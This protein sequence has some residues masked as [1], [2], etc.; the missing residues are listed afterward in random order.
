MRNSQ[1]SASEVSMRMQVLVVVTVGLSLASCHSSPNLQTRLTV[2]SSYHELIDGAPI[3]I[4]GK[5]IA[6]K[7]VGPEVRS[8]DEHRYPLRLRHVIVQVENTLK[9]TADAGAFYRY[10]WSPDHAMVGPWGIVGPG[11]RCVFSLVKEDGVLRSTMDLYPSHIE[12]RSGKHA[13]YSPAA[14]QNARESIAELLL[15]PGDDV[16]PEA[17]AQSLLIASGRSIDLVGGEV[18]SRLMK[19]PPTHKDPYLREQAC[20][21]MLERFRGAVQCV[22]HRSQ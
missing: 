15:T 14:G 2:P 11:E 20:L 4:V 5:V 16:H 21:V 8:R 13:N 17:F 19:P 1:R 10:D 7:V 6:V 3:V 22:P 18:T 12:I 9:G